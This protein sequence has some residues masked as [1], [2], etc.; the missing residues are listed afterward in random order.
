MKSTNGA[1]PCTPEMQTINFEKETD[2][3]ESNNSSQPNDDAAA[4]TTNPPAS[5]AFTSSRM[6]K[7]FKT[8]STAKTEYYGP[9]IFLDKQEEFNYTF[10]I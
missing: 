6:G 3:P 4:K 1:A 9:F 8:L 10:G 7:L 2:G 5:A